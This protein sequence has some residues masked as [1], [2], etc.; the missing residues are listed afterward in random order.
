MSLED[1]LKDIQ[2][3]LKLADWFS[4][5]EHVG[6]NSDMPIR[7]LQEKHENFQVFQ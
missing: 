1:R 3:A 7:L 5:E 4:T 2:I 6:Y